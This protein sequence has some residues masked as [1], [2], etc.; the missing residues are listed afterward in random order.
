MHQH[1][2]RSPITP[3]SVKPPRT[4]SEKNNNQKEKEDNQEDNQNVESS[5]AATLGEDTSRLGE[6]A[7]AMLK[8]QEA[9]TQ[10]KESVAKLSQIVQVCSSNQFEEQSIQ[11]MLLI[12]LL[13]QGCFDH[14]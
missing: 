5:G 7:R 12:E 10:G 13:H 4:S 11:L 14:T 8:I 6:V 2:R 1:P 3:L 9:S